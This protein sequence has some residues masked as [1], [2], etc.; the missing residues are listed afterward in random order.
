MPVSP[1]DAEL[2]QQALAGS[3]AAYQT[4]VSRYGAAAVNIAARMVR[5]RA[6][7]EDL[8]Q[9]AFVRAFDR[10]A[11]YNPQHRFAGWFFQILHHVTIDHLR[12]KRLPT[13]SLD[14]LEAAGH[15]GLPTRAAADSPVVQAEHA[16]LARA[17]ES[18]LADV[19]PEYREAVV[20]RYRENLPVHEIADVMGVPVGTVKTYLFRARKELASILTNRGWG[21]KPRSGTTRKGSERSW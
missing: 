4:L 20:L 16:A 10:L 6:L 2:S 12:R 9:E 13:V 14:E 7:A 21:L 8:A 15:T 3:Q 1:S 18:A 17:L 19:R 11:S 5:D